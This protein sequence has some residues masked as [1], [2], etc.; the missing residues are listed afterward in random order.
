MSAECPLLP[1][2]HALHQLAPP[3]A[4]VADTN[5]DVEEAL[6]EAAHG[7]FPPFRVPWDYKHSTKRPPGDASK[8]ETDARMVYPPDPEVDPDD[9]GSDYDDDGSS[10]ASALS[11]ALLP[12][13]N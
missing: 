8:Q 3:L 5:G 12:L 7:F 6:W 11:A 1:L 4:Q 13:A 9:G 10:L 2:L